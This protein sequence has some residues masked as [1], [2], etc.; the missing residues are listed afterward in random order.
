MI[1]EAVAAIRGHLS[2]ASLATAPFMSLPLVSPSSVVMTAAL[3]S[4]WTHGPVSAPERA[5]LP[6]DDGVNDLPPHLGRSLLHRR[7]DDV[8][9]ACGWVAPVHAMV[10]RDGYDR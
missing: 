6:D 2:A 5:P 1:V 3:S 7:D 4:N 10:S 8:A 9:D